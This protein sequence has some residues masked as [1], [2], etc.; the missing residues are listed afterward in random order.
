MKKILYLL[1]MVM[2]VLCIFNFTNDF[3]F[4]DR[5]KSCAE[6]WTNDTGFGSLNSLTS[7]FDSFPNISE[8]SAPLEVLKSV[9]TWIGALFNCV[10]NLVSFVLVSVVKLIKCLGII[11]FGVNGS[12]IVSLYERGVIHY[13]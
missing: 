10:A 5:I 9:F 2:F 6:L 8:A 4:Y 7:S 12:G 13:V 11:L 1:F 3:S